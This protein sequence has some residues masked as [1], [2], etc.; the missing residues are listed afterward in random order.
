VKK[1]TGH[2][3]EL[4]GTHYQEEQTL[5]GEGHWHNSGGGADGSEPWYHVLGEI[6]SPTTHRSLTLRGKILMDHSWIEYDAGVQENHR[7]GGPAGETYAVDITTDTYTTDLRW[8]HIVQDKLPGTIGLSY[9]RKSSTSIGI[10]RLLPDYTLDALGLYSYYRWKLHTLTFSGGLRLDGNSYDIQATSFPGLALVESNRRQS[11][12]IASGSL[13]LIWHEVETPYSLAMNIGT[14]WRPAN[15]YELYIN[16]IHH[17]D[18]KIELGDPDLQ[19]EHAVNTD[20]ILRHVAGSH[21]GELTFFYNRMRNYIFSSPTGNRDASTGIPIYQ[22]SQGD[23]HTYGSEMRLEY[24]LGEYLRAD[25]GWDVMWGELLDDVIDADGDGAVEYALPSMNP[26]RLLAGF[27]YEI[28]KLA[29]LHD[30]SFE[31][32]GEYVFAQEN[33]AEMENL[34]DDGY[35]NATF[36]EPQAYSLLDVAVHG[37]MDLGITSLDMSLGVN[38]LLNAR[39]YGHL[40][41]YKGLVYDQGFNAYGE[42][43]LKF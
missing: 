43:R 42:L 31:M 4:L 25:I 24:M 27:H 41:R 20:L 21:T 5:I 28:G 13:G 17:G 34:I 40:S 9:M 33:L 22:I 15:P 3:V 36:L 8:R 19:E 10:E 35:G 30:V 7:Q 11:F 16:G 6:V 39:Y 32:N 38:N 23:A 26:P 12:P 14:G 1:F 37:A 18:W 29:M 2:E